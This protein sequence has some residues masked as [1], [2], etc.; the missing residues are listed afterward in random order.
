MSEISEYKPK[1]HE[2]YFLWPL[3]RIWRR[4]TAIPW[5]IKWF[6]QRGKRGYADCDIW[7]IDWYLSSWLPKALRKLKEIS[8][9]CPQ[10]LWDSTK[11]DNECWKWNA[12]LEE[13]TQGFEAYRSICDLEFM[14]DN[15]DEK[16]KKKERELHKK[17]EKGLE[18]FKKYYFHLWD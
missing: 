12:I 9:G 5:K 2:K 17:F 7:S 15:Y 18:L 4:A 6:I 10:E 1:F 3:W 14:R 16:A 8:G 11:K 13:I